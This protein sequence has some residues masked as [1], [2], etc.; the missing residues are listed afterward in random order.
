VISED[1]ASDQNFIRWIYDAAKDREIKRSANL[2][3]SK[4]KAYQFIQENRPKL[5]TRPHKYFE[6]KIDRGQETGMIPD[7]DLN[8]FF[9]VTE[10]DA[11]FFLAIYAT[12]EEVGN[13]TQKTEDDLM[14]GEL[15][16]RGKT[17]VTQ[18]I[19]SA[20]FKQGVMV[21]KITGE[22][23]RI[24]SLLDT[25]W[26]TRDILTTFQDPFDERYRISAR[27]S[28]NRKNKYNLIKKSDP[29][30]IEINVPL[31][32]DVLSDPSM[33]NYL[34]N[35][36]KVKILKKSMTENVEKKMNEYIERTQQE[37]KGETFHLSVPIRKEFSTLREFRDF[38][39]MKS[40]P[41]AEIRLK[42]DID[43][44]EFGRQTKLPSLQE[45]RD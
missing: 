14:A 26:D 1:L 37:F 25:T 39:W 21:G 27:I 9:R 38:D 30:V 3:V 24:S 19:G 28:Q 40:Y 34:K 15:K 17:N 11:D 20:V 41:D 8:G 45:V 35:K 6:L 12:T 36:E 16:V 7:T 22:E 10:S 4:E 18:F 42:V 5:E 23:T 43:F 29:P 13:Q 31:F 44:G 32:I 33:S 2:I